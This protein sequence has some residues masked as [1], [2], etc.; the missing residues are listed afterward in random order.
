[1]TTLSC[2]ALFV[3][4]VPRRSLTVLFSCALAACG[5]GGSGG[6]GSGGSGGG[7]GDAVYNGSF[8]I[9]GSNPDGKQP[10]GWVREGGNPL[11]VARKSGS[12]F[13]P[14]DG[15]FFVEFPAS[16]PWIGGP[17]E[18][19]FLRMYQ[20]DVDLSGATDLVFDF[21]TTNI[22][23]SGPGSA[24]VRIYF[25]PNSGGGGTIDLWTKTYVPG[26]VPEQVRG[27]SAPL[28]ALPVP[29]RLAFEV[30]STESIVP[31]PPGGNDIH[32]LTT[33]TFRLDF[34]AA[35]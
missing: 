2:C 1:M 25:Q 21:E 19:P 4:R 9:L 34:V 5:S 6:A 12:G 35:Q 27:E 10:D 16:G 14:S 24:T 26:A 23:M 11:G 32:T 33:F 7:S 17:D 15:Q 31:A 3:G 8:E 20:D 18:H 30:T 28:P 13:M 22:S 29:G